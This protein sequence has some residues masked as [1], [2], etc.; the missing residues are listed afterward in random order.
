LRGLAAAQHTLPGEE[1]FGHS[2]PV[3]RPTQVAGPFAAGAVVS[4]VT[5]GSNSTPG[6]VPGT[7]KTVVIPA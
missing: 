1:E 6:V 5:R 2:V 4:F 3:A 7:P